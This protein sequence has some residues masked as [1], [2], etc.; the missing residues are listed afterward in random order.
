M[1]SN[2]VCHTRITSM[3]ID[4]YNFRERKNSQVMKERETLHSNTYKGDVNIL[5]SP[6]LLP[7]CSGSPGLDHALMRYL[8][9][10]TSRLVI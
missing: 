5:R 1:E 9:V 3:I 7:N 6:R 2:S 4:N 10:P 8:L